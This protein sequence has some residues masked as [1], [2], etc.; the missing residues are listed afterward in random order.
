VK[1]IRAISPRIWNILMMG[2][3]IDAESWQVPEF[4]DT[5]FNGGTIS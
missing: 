2:N 5:E 3:Q 1:D 4:L